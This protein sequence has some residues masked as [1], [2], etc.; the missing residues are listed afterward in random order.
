MIRVLVVDDQPLMR[1]ILADILESSPE[2]VVVGTACN[3]REAVELVG[4]REVDVVAMDLHMPEMDGVEAARE[5]MRSKPCPI[6]V[7]H[8]SWRGEDTSAVSEALEAGAVAAV[9]KIMGH[10]ESEAEQFGIHLREL[11]RRAAGG[12]ADKEQGAKG[13]PSRVDECPT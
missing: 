10:G 3:G 11:V 2:I 1:E 13:G 5:I 9:E 12:K 6:V 8:G 7:L 4:A